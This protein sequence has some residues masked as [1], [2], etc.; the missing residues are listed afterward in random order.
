[1]SF[2]FD[3]YQALLL[4]LVA[5]FAY[6]GYRR[7]GWGELGYTLGMSLVLLATVVFPA[8]FIGFV[9]RV[10]VNIPRV[11]GLLLGVNAPTVDQGTLFGEPGSGRFLLTRVVLFTLLSFLVYN[12]VRY[13]WLYEAPGKLRAAPK[14]VFPRLLGLV[15]GAVSGFLWF[16]AINDFLNALRGLRD[17]PRLPL[18]GTTITLPT[19]GDTTALLSFVPTIFVVLLVALLIAAA[20]RLPNLWK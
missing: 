7:G 13:P 20:I 18:E 11:F 14:T 16:L 2:T 12:Q 1:M 10:I 4:P 3:N 6:F 5:A 8:Q 9:D 19:I 17:D 15:L